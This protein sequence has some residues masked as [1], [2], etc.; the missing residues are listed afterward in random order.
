LT[1]RQDRFNTKI[2]LNAVFLSDIY[3]PAS[4][5]FNSQMLQ[6]IL[7]EVHVYIFC[8]AGNWLFGWYQSGSETFNYNIVRDNP[9]F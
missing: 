3:H 8:R 4:L 6:S 7:P 5:F 2:A 1:L 9:Q